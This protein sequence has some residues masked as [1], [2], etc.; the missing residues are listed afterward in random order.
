MNNVAWTTVEVSRPVSLLNSCHERV[1]FPRIHAGIVYSDC[2]TVT[3][4]N[5]KWRHAVV[6]AAEQFL[7]CPSFQ[8]A[9]VQ[10]ACFHFS[11]VNIKNS[12]CEWVQFILSSA[13]SLEPS[14]ARENGDFCICVTKAFLE[15][16]IRDTVV[17]GCHCEVEVLKSAVLMYSMH[18]KTN[19][20]TD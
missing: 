16:R 6:Y 20:N 4:R 10:E 17:F 19:N 18:K 7:R 9:H 5:S 14:V 8:H 13:L 12:H 1:L 15:K 3:P 11:K 2:Y